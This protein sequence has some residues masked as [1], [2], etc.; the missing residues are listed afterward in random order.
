VSPQEFPELHPEARQALQAG[1]RAAHPFV[2]PK[3][4]WT[5]STRRSFAAFLRETMYQATDSGCAFSWRK[6]LAIAD[7]I[8]SPPPPPPPPPTLAEA[9]KAARRLAGED[10]AILHAFLAA[11]GKGGQP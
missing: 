1:Y 3:E 9:R 10:A 6:L 7:N 11:L 8:H 5:E 2:G 4:D